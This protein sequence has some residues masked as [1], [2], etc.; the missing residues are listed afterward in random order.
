MF[1]IFFPDRYVASAYVIDFERLFKQG[2]RGLVFDIDNTLV[3]HGE[4]ADERA[5]RLFLLYNS[6][7]N[8]IFLLPDF[9]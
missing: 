4:P 6:V 1:D 8:R 5:V 9:K 3:P 2:Y 7:L